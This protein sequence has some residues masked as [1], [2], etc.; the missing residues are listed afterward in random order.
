MR[1]RR[2][3]WSA[4]LTTRA[5]AC[6][7]RHG[8]DGLWHVFTEAFSCG[9]GEAVLEV[10]IVKDFYFDD[11]TSWYPPP[12]VAAR[13]VDLNPKGHPTC[14]RLNT[15]AFHNEQG[16]QGR[17]HRLL[18]RERHGDVCPRRRLREARNDGYGG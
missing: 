2:N 8:T 16:R 10:K 1:R 11:E 15:L 7:R 12:P 6:A 17:C 3:C 14:T 9:D 18:G 13:A 4:P 5:F